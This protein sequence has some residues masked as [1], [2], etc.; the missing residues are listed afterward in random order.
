M[1]EEGT[2]LEGKIGLIFGV[3]NKRSIAWGIAQ[4]LAGA[5]ARLAFTYIPTIDK[6]EQNVRDLAGTLPGSIC[7]PCN[8]QDDADIEAA[9]KIVE[10]ELGGLDILVH[11]V[12]YAPKEALDGLLV[13]T[14]REDFHTALDIS[15]YSLIPMARYAFPLMEKRGGGSIIAMTYGASQRVVQKYNVMAVAKAAL[16]TT[17]RYLASEGGPS[18]IR[19]NAISAGPVK[20]LSARG[21]SGFSG[22]EEHVRQVAPLRRATDAAEVGDTALFL[23]GPWGR[24][25][26]GQVVYCDSGHSIMM[27]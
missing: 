3:A 18:N 11:S 19:V 4:S 24:G 7:I 26:T 1:T 17:V 15:S 14:R 21:I 9:F 25:V 16:E 12:A 10:Q 20:T 23:C 6:V 8:V 2:L 27:M 13:N 22:M 5:G